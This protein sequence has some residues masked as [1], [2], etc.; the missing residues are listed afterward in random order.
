MNIIY[1]G[2]KNTQ[3][4]TTDLLNIHYFLAAS[5]TLSTTHPL[6]RLKTSSVS[7]VALDKKHAPTFLK[8]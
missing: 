1:S 8:K 4:L 2:D 6:V 3:A 5:L 7:G